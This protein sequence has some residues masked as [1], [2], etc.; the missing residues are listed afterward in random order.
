MGFFEDALEWIHGLSI[1]SIP[2]DT[3]NNLKLM[4]MET[5]GAAAASLYVSHGRRLLGEFRSVGLDSL[6]ILSIMLD[7]DSAVYYGHIGHGVIYGALRGVLEGREVSGEDLVVSSLAA[8]EL[9]A[10]LGAS[11][12]LTKGQT[13][14]TFL[15]S[16]STALILS[17]MSGMDP[18]GMFSALAYAMS[19]P[20]RPSIR[21]FGTLAKVLTAYIGALHGV[22]SFRLAKAGYGEDPSIIETLLRSWVRRPMVAAL[23]GLGRRWH[24]D[25][26]SIKKYPSC[27]YALTA[28]DAALK[29]REYI[30]DPS[31]IEVLIIRENILTYLMDLMFEQF[32][33]GPDSPFTVLEFYTPYLV[34]HTLVR[35]DPGPGMY[36]D[37]STRDPLVWRLTGRV[38]FTHDSSLT[39]NS[40]FYR[41]FMSSMS[42]LSRASLFLRIAPIMLRYM[43][44]RESM[45]R[46]IEFDESSAMD[47]TIIGALSRVVGSDV[48]DHVFSF[49]EEKSTMGVVLEA[50]LSY[51]RRIDV[52][53]DI[54]EGLHGTGME[55]K[56]RVALDKLRYLTSMLNE[57]A[58]SYVT[59]A[60]NNLEKLSPSE[61]RELVKCVLSVISRYTDVN[62]MVR[63][64]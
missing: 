52:R 35:G 37:T 8:S 58:A 4:F 10:R 45:R 12:T 56:R 24:M 3:L 42:P 60:L 34:S 41:R 14:T 19:F 48:V 20:M 2:S 39:R 7:Y 6:P 43:R 30:S 25:T 15:A 22:S 31:N 59:E 44:M 9:V 51:G 64:S 5:L 36:E 49:S 21:G 57:D 1:N 11:V 27:Y 63:L 54:T 23:G 29:L 32:V 50:R 38:R 16:V 61:A 26:L 47:D 55:A 46:V 40:P 18:K 17:R 28:I 33:R 53:S 13:L 62:N